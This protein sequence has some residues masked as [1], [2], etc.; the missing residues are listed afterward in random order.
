[1]MMSSLL[2][3]YMGQREAQVEYE[4]LFNHR[5]HCFSFSF[6]MMSSHESVEQ[7]CS[8]QDTPKT[9]KVTAKAAYTEQPEPD[10]DFIT[11][12]CC[13]MADSHVNNSLMAC[14]G[15]LHVHNTK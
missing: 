12:G 3:L 13:R 5:S 8:H 2:P 7:A 6:L 10:T 11:I 1:M 14:I 9:V 15:W 4:L